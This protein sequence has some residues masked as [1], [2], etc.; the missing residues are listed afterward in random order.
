[1]QV[2]VFQ[3]EEHERL[4]LFEPELRAAGFEAVYRFRAPRHEDVN[5]PLLVV[6]GGGM[7]VYETDLHPFLRQELAVLHERLSQD[8]PCLGICL[9]AQL[10]AAALGSEVFAGKNGLEVGAAKIRWAKGALEDPVLAGMRQELV[11]AHWHKD[12]YK[13]VPGATLL[14]STSRYVQQGFKSGRSYAFQ[15]HPELTAAQLGVW[16]EQGKTTLEA[17]GHSAPELQAGLPK[18]KAS[19][20]ELHQLAQRLADHFARAARA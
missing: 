18:L 6:L 1:M 9:G 10:M 16:I 17:G 4:G 20:G 7:G 5:A 12:T 13:P 11:V 14:A 3:H 19:E 2:V 15:F 8:R